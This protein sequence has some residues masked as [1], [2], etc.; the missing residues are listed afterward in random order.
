MGA[1][2]DPQVSDALQ[3]VATVNVRDAECTFLL[4]ER[5]SLSS[6]LSIYKK[7]LVKCAPSYVICY[8]LVGRIRLIVKSAGDMENKD[9]DTVVTY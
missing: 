4:Y 2:R 6:L 1:L 5:D 7:L 9:I 8:V 3:R